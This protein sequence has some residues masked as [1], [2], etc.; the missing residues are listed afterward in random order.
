M[1]SKFSLFL[2]ESTSNEWLTVCMCWVRSWYADFIMASDLIS[3]PVNE[4]ISRNSS[5]IWKPNEYDSF[6]RDEKKV[7][8]IVNS[9]GDDMSGGTFRNRL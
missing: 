4:F 6:S 1:N 5:V 2:V 8:N 3:S 7:Q 9:S